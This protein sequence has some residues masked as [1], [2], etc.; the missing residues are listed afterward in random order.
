MSEPAMTLTGDATALIAAVRELGELLP[1]APGGTLQLK[2]DLPG[3]LRSLFVDRA[4]DFRLDF[5]KL[6]CSDSHPA[7]DNAFDVL[8][9]FKPSD[10]FLELLAALRAGQLDFDVIEQ[11]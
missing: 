9:S 3:N 10:L 5:S 6:V 7:A 1:A 11:V 2:G 4:F 8:I